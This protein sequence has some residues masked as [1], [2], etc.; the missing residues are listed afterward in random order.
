MI[1]WAVAKSCLKYRRSWF[2]RVRIGVQLFDTALMQQGDEARHR[3]T[4]R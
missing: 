2:N 4:E 3:I 1:V